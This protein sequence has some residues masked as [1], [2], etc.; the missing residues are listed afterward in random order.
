MELR[1]QCRLYIMNYAP[2]IYVLSECS[3]DVEK[4]DRIYSFF[5]S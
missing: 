2:D 5:I 1:H 4:M 3:F